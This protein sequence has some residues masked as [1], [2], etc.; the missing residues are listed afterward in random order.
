MRRHRYWEADMVLD[1]QTIQAIQDA[2]D[3]GNRVELIPVR[4]GVRAM[5]IRRKELNQRPASKR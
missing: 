5:E 3:R 4:D 1:A 2:L